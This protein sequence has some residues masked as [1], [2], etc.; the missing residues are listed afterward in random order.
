[1]ISWLMLTKRGGG[2]IIIPIDKI[3]YVDYDDEGVTRVHIPN[4]SL[5]GYIRIEEE[6]TEVI[7]L[8]RYLAE[9]GAN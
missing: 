2:Q 6:L 4:A 1:M 3:Q 7:E 5:Y 9:N 8:I